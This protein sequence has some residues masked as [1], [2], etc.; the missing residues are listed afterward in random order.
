MEFEKTI[1][2][3]CD[4]QYIEQSVKKGQMVLFEGNNQYD[5]AVY[6]HRNG[7]LEQDARLTTQYRIEKDAKIEKY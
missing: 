4:L 6:I 5:V 1:Y 3:R 2:D 7:A